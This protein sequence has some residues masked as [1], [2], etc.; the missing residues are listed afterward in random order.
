MV[1]VANSIK[2]TLG[3][4]S[5]LGSSIKMKK[6][7]MIE[8]FKSS[9]QGHLFKLELSETEQNDFES[10]LNELPEPSDLNL[11]FQKAMEDDSKMKQSNLKPVDEET[12]L[13]SERGSTEWKHWHELGLEAHRKGES[14]VVT[15]AGGQGTR[16]GS[17]DPKGCYKIG[18]PSGASLFQLQAERVL[19]IE[20]MEVRVGRRSA[21]RVVVVVV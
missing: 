4:L 13:I 17:L 7:K 20:K 21:Q 12:I 3:S 11:M 2:T 15:L 18:L 8:Q 9:Q 16:L 1:T 6:M 10:Q 5:S 14:C 19:K